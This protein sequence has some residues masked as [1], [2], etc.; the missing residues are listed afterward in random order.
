L[1]DLRVGAS[2]PL[3]FAA[4]VAGVVVAAGCSVG[5]A[6][7][8]WTFGVEPS[9]DELGVVVAWVCAFEVAANKKTRAT[10]ARR[11]VIDFMV[12]HQGVSGLRSLTR[13]PV[14]NVERFLHRKR[15]AMR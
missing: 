7:G 6:A 9:P 12:C 14:T 11:L 2:F 10:G 3:V 8:A 1:R 5:V 4:L 13:R 15:N